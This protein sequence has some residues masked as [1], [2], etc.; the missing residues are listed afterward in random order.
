MKDLTQGPI[1]KHILQLS[2]FLAVSMVFQTLYYLVDL[3]F[4]SRIGKEAIAGVGLA[5]N[6]MFVTLALTQMLGVGTATLISHAAGRKDQA[7]AQLVF[8]QSFVFSML[9]GLAVV[10]L[11][12]L[13]RGPYTRWLSA[14]ALTTKAGAD[15]LL[16]FV[17]AIGLQFA[18]ISM[19]SALRGT[20]IVKPTMM[21]Q[22]FT[23][24]MNVVLAP[25]L[26]A[27]WLTHH[28]L[29]V[30]GAGLAT[31]IALVFG[32]LLLTAYFIKLESYVWFE[33]LHWR[34]QLRIWKQM[35]DI[36]LPAGGEFL[37][38]G[39]YT[40]VVY[41]IIRNFG[42]A[43]QAGF[44]IGGRVMQAIFLPVI[45]ISFA[46]SPV[47]GQNFG[48]R[49]AG[50][51]RQ[52]FYSAASIATGCMFVLTLLCQISP[53][54]LIRIFSHEPQV[55]EFGAEF[56]RI[57]SW[58]FVAYGLIFTS[59]ATFQGLGNTWPPLA[60]SALRLLI[61]ATPAALL[62]LRAGF[63]IHQVWYLSVATVGI[64]AVTNVFLLRR[65]FGRKLNF[66]AQATTVPVSA[67]VGG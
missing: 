4:V 43:A 41:W 51:V 3:Y 28:P 12:Y 56:L 57:I 25:I 17:P 9:V 53:Q 30:R 66:A 7:R 23:V 10:V 27:G 29:G 35:T 63:T 45:A 55:I 20:G 50:R 2:I 15:Y 31:F 49:L 22:I 58:N 48:A 34:P 14:D 36:G 13:C 52:T 60:S 54:T 39:V 64:Q 44:G 8:N 47:A 38:M 5:G 19:A 40:A 21:V 1:T 65:E 62:S 37:L 67:V 46:A 16:W 61:F 6:L 59:S 32:V 18:L 42:A 24:L 33:R 11:G 26:I